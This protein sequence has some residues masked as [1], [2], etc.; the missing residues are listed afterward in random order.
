MKDDKVG[1]TL[2]ETTCIGFIG[3]FVG[4]ALLYFVITLKAMEEARQMDA[5]GSASHLCG[6][7]AAATSLAILSIPAGALFGFCLGAFFLWRKS[8]ARRRPLP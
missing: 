3:G 4:G 8:I 6:A 5:P 7:G 2:F 1:G